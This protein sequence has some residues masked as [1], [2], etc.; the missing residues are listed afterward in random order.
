[1]KTRLMMALAFA[2]L[3]ISLRADL[4]VYRESERAHITVAGR[5]ATVAITTYVVHDTTTQTADAIG[6][7]K[8][9]PNKFYAVTNGTK[10][11][12]TQGIAGRLGSYTVFSNTAT[13][14]DDPDVITSSYFAKGRDSTLDLGNG[15]SISLPRSLQA[16]TRAVQRSSGNLAI[17]E[18]TSTLIFQ[19]T[20]T[21][22]ANEA[23]DT[24]AAVIERIRQRLE[25]QGYRPAP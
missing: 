9:G 6:A 23:G 4:V 7:F 18:S 14:N 5:E 8:V 19:S 25:A 20:E 1:M 17:Y 21:K 2:V 13:T 22:T 12:I 16:V 3:S 11:V 10:V 24:R 15:H